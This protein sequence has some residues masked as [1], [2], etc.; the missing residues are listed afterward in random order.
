MPVVR[1]IRM[2]NALELSSYCAAILRLRAAVPLVHFTQALHTELDCAVHTIQ[3]SVAIPSRCHSS[4]SSS[5]PLPPAP[6]Q[7]SPL[8]AS[9]AGLGFTDADSLLP[10]AQDGPGSDAP[11]FA[12]FDDVEDEVGLSE[13]VED[14]DGCLTPKPFEVSFNMTLAMKQQLAEMWPEV[15][16]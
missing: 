6:I 4:T 1:R 9:L 8:L 7:Q 16:T 12:G 15:Q 3:S 13:E 14:D 2:M 11:S 5:S 10:A